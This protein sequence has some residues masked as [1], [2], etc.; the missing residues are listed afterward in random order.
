M[1]SA[2]TLA[3][4]AQWLA[5]RRAL[6]EREKELTRLR[7]EL[8]EERR[9]LPWVPVE[10]HYE[11]DTPDGVRTLAELFDGRSQLLVYHFMF[12]PDWT[13]GCP[14]CSFWADSFDGAVL[15]LR[16]RDVTM[17]AVSRAPLDALL[18]YR[19][20]MGW[21]FAW[22]SSLRNDFNFDYGV[23]FTESQRA[24]GAEYNYRL[25]EKP[26]EERPGLSAFA[27]GEDG[28]VYHTYSCYARGLDPI[29]SAYQ[30]LDLAPKG[31]DEG[32]L[33]WPMAW[34]RRHDAYD[35]VE[36]S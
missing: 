9:R 15:H 22:V 11:F 29:N 5:E 16:H 28:T 17:I 2:I 7:D 14:S 12:G 23:S 35:D 20:R 6:L 26:G 33:P 19:E 8:A 27:I 13:E 10:K 1:T 31:R 21:S 3:T 18:A 32:G 25:V 30:L 4:R 36:A 34:V 24:G